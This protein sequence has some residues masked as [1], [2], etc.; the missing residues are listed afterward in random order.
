MRAKTYFDVLLRKAVHHVGFVKYLPGPLPRFHSVERRLII[1]SSV[2]GDVDQ[3]TVAD[4]F[5]LQLRC[6]AML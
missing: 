3:F 6:E 2:T 1:L 4:H 5:G